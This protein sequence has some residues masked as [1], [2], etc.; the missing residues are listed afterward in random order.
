MCYCLVLFFAEVKIFRFW[1]KTMDYNKAFWP[2]LSSFFVV[3]LLQSGRC[4]KAEIC[5]ILF[6]L[7]CAICY[8]LVL[9]FAVVKIFR[10]WPKTMDYNKAFWPK[11]SSFFVV[12]L[13]QSGRCYKAE[14]CTVLFPLRCAIAWYY[15]FPKSKFS[16]SGQK[17]WTI[18]RRFDRNR[19]HSLSPFYSKVEGATKLKFAPFCSP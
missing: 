2:K 1:P 5:T 18:I 15:F 7:R 16:D 19:V 4:Y 17:P 6:P 14:I 8:C 13:L 11:L 9:F 12:F 3:F 10:F